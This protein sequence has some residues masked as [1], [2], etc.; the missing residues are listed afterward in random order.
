MVGEGHEGARETVEQL[1]RLVDL[2]EWAANIAMRTYGGREPALGPW[3]NTRDFMEEQGRSGD[4]E[5]MIELFE[6]AGCRNEIEA[7]LWL[8]KVGGFKPGA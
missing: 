5:R 3:D 8:D 6:G 1:R 2:K 4:A 7:V